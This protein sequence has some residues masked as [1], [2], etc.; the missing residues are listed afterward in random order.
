M[1]NQST[2]PLRHV[3][4]GA[5]AGIFKLHEGGLNLDTT[6]LVGLCD[7]NP[8]AEEKLAEHNVPLLYRPHADAGRSAA[9]RGRGHH[10]SPPFTHRW[11]LMR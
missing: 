6:E 1:A 2:A 5:G 7:V 9:R 11:R 3:V 4:I 10:T 8:A